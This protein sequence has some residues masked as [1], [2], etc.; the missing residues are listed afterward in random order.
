MKNLRELINEL[1]VIA[2][3]K[4]V[5]KTKLTESAAHETV[6]YITKMK[7]AFGDMEHAEEN[8][9]E[10][11]SF[12]PDVHSEE[13]PEEEKTMEERVSELEEEVAALK[14]KLEEPKA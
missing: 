5:G 6:K 14:A 7:E 2:T 1:E 11:N 8:P 12:A 9:E 4:V 10:K 3:A 13:Q